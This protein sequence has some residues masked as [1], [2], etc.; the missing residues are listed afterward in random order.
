MNKEFFIKNRKNLS[1][2]LEDNSILV[3]FAGDAPYRSADY[4]YSFVPNR[5]FYYIAGFPRE[6][7]IFMLLKQDGQVSESLFIERQDPVMARWIGEK[8]SIEES[9]DLTGIENIKYLDQFHES[10]GRI[11]GDMI[12][13]NIYLDL[14]RQEYNMASSEGVNF[15]KEVL[16]RYPFFKVKNVFDYIA[17]LRVIKSEEEIELIKKAI[18]ITKEG[19][20]NMMSN[21]RVGMIEY[22]LEACFDYTLRKN[23][24]RNTAFNT[25]IGSGKN[26]TVLHYEENNC[27][28]KDEN[29]VLLD[30]GAQYE[31]YNGD[32]SRT[33]PING[34]FTERQKAVY[35]VVLRAQK[36]IEAAVKPGVMWKDINELSKKELAKGCKELGLI[37]E[38][39][40]LSNYYFHSFGHFL[41]L[42]THDVGQYNIPL[43]PG[44]VLTNEPGLY[45]SEE[46][47]GIRIEDDLLVAEDGC[48]NL[49]KDIIKEIDEIE[50]FMAKNKR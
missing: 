9:K 37:K 33:F 32:I 5:N 1:E 4:K 14:E 17:N 25:I 43:Q 24:V 23:G 39:S 34:K 50:E 6:K 22:E 29:L 12:I 47:I 28:V 8:L 44:M 19:I 48:I 45:I 31:L 26:G 46:G 7:A 49:S 36:A 27:E 11:G 42:D 15:A 16:E 38:D 3:L 2:K 21:A 40:E 30:L 20:Y 18:N 10:F 35:N 41:G 13:E